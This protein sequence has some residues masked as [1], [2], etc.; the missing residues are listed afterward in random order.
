MKI[1]T[2]FLS[3]SCLSLF[4]L[5]VY[6]QQQISQ[7]EHEWREKMRNSP[8]QQQGTKEFIKAPLRLYWGGRGE[9]RMAF[10]FLNDT[11]FRTALGIS[12]KQHQQIL[13]TTGRFGADVLSNNS[14]YMKLADEVLVLKSA[15]D[16]YRL[17]VDEE[18]MRIMLNYQK[19]NATL[20]ATHVVDTMDNN[21]T[22]EQKQKVKTSLLANMAEV[23]IVSPGMFDVLDL[24]D[25]QK[26]EMEEI[27]KE[28]ES[29]FEKNLEILAH[30]WMLLT[31]KMA[32]ELD[33]QGIHY[34]GDAGKNTLAVHKKLMEDPAYK[35]IHD[36]IM[37][38][39]KA[40][41]AQSRTKM[42]DVLTDTQWKRLQELIDNPPN[43]AKVF[44]KKLKQKRGETEKSDVWVPGPKSWRPGDPIPE[45]YRQQRQERGRF[46]RGNQ[47]E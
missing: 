29:E 36:D 33:K 27:K 14:E 34:D 15:G 8:V 18:T 9:Y 20:D 39:G 28:L 42:F 22:A 46:P 31:D 32:E 26:K 43:Y 3:L 25:T 45:G 11:E 4:V 41:S 19:M 37:S 6:S 47:S 17:D 35:K 40:F 5:A 44:L 7:R 13:D 23:P 16:V 1:K 21:L 12:D 38:Q 2:L 24:T 30:G 10:D